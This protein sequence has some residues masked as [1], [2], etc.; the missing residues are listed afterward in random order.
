MRLR[1]PRPQT[2]FVT[3]MFSLV[4]FAALRHFHISHSAAWLLWAAVMVWTIYTASVMIYWLMKSRKMQEEIE[5]IELLQKKSVALSLSW[6]LNMTFFL[7]YLIVALVYESPWFGTLAFFYI[8]L[9][10][11]RMVLLTESRFKRPNIRSQW[12]SYMT[13]GYLMMA[14]MVALIIM[15]VMVVEDHY[16]MSYPGHT[17]WAAGIFALYLTVSALHGYFT[18]KK[19]RSPMLSA[20]RVIAM[21][22]ALLGLYSFQTAML[23]RTGSDDMTVRFWNIT[24]GVLISIIMLAISLYMIVHGGRMLSYKVPSDRK[25]R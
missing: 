22:A 8:S 16:S 5:L 13:C 25:N 1:Y 19:W 11:G 4:A 12:R 15:A 7:Y 10:V 23:G 18:T 21:S 6:I 9:S 14:M 17:I 3:L 24:T 2:I 20:E